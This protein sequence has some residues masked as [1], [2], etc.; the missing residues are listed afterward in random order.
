MNPPTVWCGPTG[1][2]LFETVCESRAQSPTTT[3]MDRQVPAIM[4]MA[5]S[6]LAAFRSFI[7]ISAI[8]WMEALEM[9]ATLVLLGTPEPDS[10]LHSFLIRT[11][12]GGVLVMKEMSGQH[13]Q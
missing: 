2:S 10:M 8:F 13:T 11:A 12:A 6:R 1:R 7:L 9:V 4:L 5:D 3:P